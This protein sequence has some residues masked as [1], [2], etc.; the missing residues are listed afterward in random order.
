M[1]PESKESFGDYVMRMEIYLDSNEVLEVTTK[2]VKT[3]PKD[4][5]G[6]LD[7]AVTEATK[8][9]HTAAN[10][11]KSK[12]AANF[13]VQSV[14]EKILR[15]LAH[16]NP[17]NAY[18]MWKTVQRIQGL[19]KTTDTSSALMNKLH[20]I[21]KDKNDSMGVYISKVE[22][23]AHQLSQLRINIDNQ[24]KKFYIL[25]GLESVEGWSVDLKLIRKL[26]KDNTWTMDEL[27]QYLMDEE[28]ARELK[29][30]AD[31]ALYEDEEEAEHDN[32]DSALYNGRGGHRGRGH[33]R[34]GN[35]G[36]HQRGGSWRGNG[37]GRGNGGQRG[38]FHGRGRGNWQERQHYGDNRQNNY[39]GGNRNNDNNDNDNTGHRQSGGGYSGKCWN[40]GGA[41]H[42]ARDCPSRRMERSDEHQQENN[43]NNNKR[44]KYNHSY[45]TTDKA[46][47]ATEDNSEWVLD[48]GS[49][50]H[51][52][53]SKELLTD[54]RKLDKARTTITGNG[55]SEFSLVGN[56]EVEADGKRILLKDVAYIPGFNANLISV[57]KMVDGGALVT[58]GKKQ[59]TVSHNNRVSFTVPR[60]SDLYVLSNKKKEEK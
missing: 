54:I 16:I 3:I 53:G 1:L 5:N 17:S 32:G 15:M 24:Q 27:Q 20:N 7:D 30:K 40:C 10:L 33:W 44:Q 6:T 35:R 49:T 59:A 48:G 45:I 9:V 39:N 2:G 21:R 60:I 51:Y 14:S 34:G 56:A 19:I 52:T 55:R 28:N 46:L 23:I 58:Y 13:I 31:A 12:K 57:A 37:R 25:K 38:G 42:P 41:G 50:R 4:K 47:A 8:L 43:N 36:G 26:D 22:N 11:Q 18:E 29:A